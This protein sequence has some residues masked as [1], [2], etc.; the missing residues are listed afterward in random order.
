MMMKALRSFQEDTELLVKETSSRLGEARFL[1]KILKTNPKSCQNPDF[2]GT[3]YLL[4]T[5]FF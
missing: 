1:E 5:S 4:M 2:L 3:G